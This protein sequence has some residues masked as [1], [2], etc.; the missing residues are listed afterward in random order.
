[1]EENQEQSGNKVMKKFESSLQKLEAITANPN[2][3]KPVKRV[4]SDQLPSIVEDLANEQKE[5]L[6]KTFKEA[7]KNLIL[8]KSA[9]DAIVEKK[10]KEFQNAVLEEVK[11]LQVKL[12][13]V[14]SMV[15]GITGIEARYFSALRSIAE[16]PTPTSPMEG[17]SG[18][19]EGTTDS[20]SPSL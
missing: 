9:H 10:K 19:Q 3:Y 15:D 12:D 17:L 14:L 16:P 11:K 4:M 6:L 20:I 13:T 5:A 7:L 2:W 1:M 18:Q 8:E